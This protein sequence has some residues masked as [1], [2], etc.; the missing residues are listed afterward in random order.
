MYMRD[1]KQYPLQTFLQV[2]I[3]SITVIKS[4]QDVEQALKVSERGLIS[5][6]I[7]LS[8]I[9]VLVVFPLL[10]KHIKSGLVLGSVKE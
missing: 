8:C 10:Q 7:T 3:A 9:P 6:Y 5:A 4:Q 2:K 1:Q